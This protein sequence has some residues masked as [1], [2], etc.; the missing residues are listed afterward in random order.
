MEWK[1]G[2]VG[3]GR[4]RVHMKERKRKGGREGGEKGGSSVE[5]ES[6][7]CHK[8]TIIRGLSATQ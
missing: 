8:T 3:R 5:Q 7:S 4:I 1:E 6:E 2:G